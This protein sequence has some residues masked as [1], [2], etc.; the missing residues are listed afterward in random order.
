MIK[1]AHD[2]YRA[3]ELMSEEQRAE[4]ID[5][6]VDKYLNKH[7][8]GVEADDDRDALRFLMAVA[9]NELVDEVRRRAREAP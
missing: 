1:I 3:Y 8:P 2:L 4:V 7:W 5:T 9:I 6:M